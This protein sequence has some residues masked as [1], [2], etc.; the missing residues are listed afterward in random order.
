MERGDWFDFSKLRVG[1]SWPKNGPQQQFF[2][3]A[4]LPI[5]I[6]GSR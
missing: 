5:S 2:E 4:E 3:F 1:R 6:I